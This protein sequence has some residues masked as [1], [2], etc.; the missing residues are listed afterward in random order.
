MGKFDELLVTGRTYL[1]KG[2]LI[3]AE[4]CF[5]QAYQYFKEADEKNG[6]VESAYWLGRL[7]SQI[8]PDSYDKAEQYFQDALDNI[9]QSDSKSISKSKILNGLGLLFY[10]RSNFTQ[11]LI[12]L[13][14][15]RNELAGRP[16]CSELAEALHY[17]GLVF[18]KQRKWELAYEC[19]DKALY[20]FKQLKDEPNL[21]GVY[22]SLGH[23]LS[24]QG[25][26]QRAI[27]FYQQ[28]LQIRRKLGDAYG[29][30][31]PLIGIGKLKLQQGKPDEAEYYFLKSLKILHQHYN[32][33]LIGNTLNNLGELYALKSEQ[34]DNDYKRAV[35]AEK[36]TKY[37]EQSITEVE[38]EF[39]T[40]FALLGLA[41][42][43]LTVDIDRS[44]EFCA[45]AEKNVKQLDF[46][47]PFQGKLLTLR[48]FISWKRRNYKEAEE[49][50]LKASQDFKE[51]DFLT[52]R[53]NVLILLGSFYQEIG[54]EKKAMEITSEAI[55][56]LEDFGAETRI[57]E[58][59]RWIQRMDRET[60]LSVIL[61]QYAE[62][63]I[64]YKFFEQIL[65]EQVEKQLIEKELRFSSE[66]VKCILPKV[67]PS[68]KTLDIA[69]KI[70]PCRAIGGDYYDIFMKNET[71]LC[72]AIADVSGKG[73]PA[74]LMM[75]NFQA[76][77][78][79]QVQKNYQICHMVKELNNTTY[80]YTP[81]EKFITFFYGEINNL[82][83]QLRYVNA[84]HDAPLLFRQEKGF[85]RLETGGLPLGMFQEILYEEDAIQLFHDDI[86]LLYTDGVT[87]ATNLQGDFFGAERLMNIVSDNSKKK[88][89]DL[90]EIIFA[91]IED[92][93]GNTPR[94]DDITIV[95]VRVL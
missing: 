25:K 91:E 54:E 71:V 72:L 6:L 10:H 2:N 29:Q 63:E 12:Y 90:C 93:E 82:N 47:H 21:A 59:Q 70:T 36:A 46:I 1:N 76:H 55:D 30:A 60:L 74:A 62:E 27:F 5:K 53:L 32:K 84:G 56:I 44:T 3:K 9:P 26:L 23:F 87:D 38:D 94:F 67:I 45:R 57:L 31:I 48:G 11:S 80:S 37:Y 95:V 13:Q 79:E 64:E 50:L 41:R 19:C 92:F 81:S 28:S 33:R 75:S 17:S 15:S 86:L 40:I 65:N 49:L 73:I 34:E 4:E 52:D 16:V 20:F 39:N 35:F 66:V 69:A 8:G 89:Q 14:K 51:N 18:H 88:A 7:Y 85:E 42:V 68:C 83:N 77:F 61:S 24:M 58:V 78:R 43:Y 22:D